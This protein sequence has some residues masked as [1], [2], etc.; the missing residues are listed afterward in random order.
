MKLS[1]CLIALSLVAAVHS[2][3]E[4]KYSTS[5]YFENKLDD[6]QGAITDILIGGENL[7]IMEG[8]LQAL[9]DDSQKIYDAEIVAEDAV[10]KNAY[11]NAWKH[12]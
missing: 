7:K 8:K 3:P 2:A 9:V 6:V 1:V 12:D 5:R 11:D 10:D 4:G